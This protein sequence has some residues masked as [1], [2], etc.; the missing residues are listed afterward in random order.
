VSEPTRTYRL[1]YLDEPVLRE[2]SVP[3]AEFGKAEAELVR[4]M[5]EIAAAHRGVGLAAPQAGVLK[6]IILVTPSILPEGAEPI[7]VNP[8]VV[9]RS[10]ETENEEEGCLSLLSIM[11]PL[12]RPARVVVKYADPEGREREVQAEG[13]GARALLHEIDHL[14]GVLFIDHLSRLKRKFVRDRFRKMYRELG[15]ERR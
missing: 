14:D 7:L 10:P 4:A 3:V 5:A 9:W 15:L 1:H 6:R 8:E 12:A 13:F 11:T 2:K